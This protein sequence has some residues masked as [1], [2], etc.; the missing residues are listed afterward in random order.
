ML[1]I[2]ISASDSHK[3]HIGDHLSFQHRGNGRIAGDK[4]M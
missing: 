3:L 1:L 4:K 2:I